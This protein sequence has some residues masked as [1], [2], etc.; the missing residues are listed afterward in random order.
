MS[1]E[2]ESAESKG[3]LPTGQPQSWPSGLLNRRARY[4]PV[5]TLAAPPRAQTPQEDQSEILLKIEIQVSLLVKLKRLRI[6]VSHFSIGKTIN[7][8][9]LI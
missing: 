3:R 1:D 9:V 2:S 4:S 6:S 5:P 7:S 8:C